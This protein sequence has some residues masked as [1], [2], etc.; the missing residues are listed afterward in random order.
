ML[1][2]RAVKGHSGRR[3]SPGLQERKE[4]ATSRGNSERVS[5]CPGR[6]GGR[7]RPWESRVEEVKL[8]STAQGG[9]GK[10]FEPLNTSIRWHPTFPLLAAP[11]PGVSLLGSSP[12]I[13]RSHSAAA[14]VG[15]FLSQGLP[16]L[17]QSCRRHDLT[18]WAAGKQGSCFPPVYPGSATGLSRGPAEM[19]AA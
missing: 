6:C 4:D 19:P 9:M 3:M 7:G 16:A 15:R 10:L 11:T 14:A 12:T 13:P 17:L 1:S 8:G 2:A 18:P 5:W